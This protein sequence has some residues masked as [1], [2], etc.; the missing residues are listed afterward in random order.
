MSL[1]DFFKEATAISSFSRDRVQSILVVGEI[2][3]ALTLMTGAGLLIRTAL[4]IMRLDPGFDTTNLLLGR[5]SLPDSAYHDSNL[6]LQTFQH[7][8]SSGDF[9]RS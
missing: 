1:S 3:L 5:I 2:A 9:T 7:R 6:A 8:R 4:Y